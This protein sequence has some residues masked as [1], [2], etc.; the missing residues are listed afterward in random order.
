MKKLI[1]IIS[2]SLLLITSTAFGF[3]WL[4]PDWRGEANTVFA[5]WDNWNADGTAD[6][7]SSTIEGARDPMWINVD[8]TYSDEW[9]GESG[10][11]QQHSNDG[12]MFWLDNANNDNPLKKIRIQVHYFGPD[13]YA[14]VDSF[15]V[16]PDDE[17][18]PEF[19]E[20]FLVDRLI[21]ENQYGA[22]G[23]VVDVYDIEIRP[24]PGE[25]YIAINFG[26]YGGVDAA[27]S[28]V[29]IDTRCVPIPGAV[30]LIASAFMA[31]VGIK[32]KVG[33]F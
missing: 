33:Q 2:L 20:A 12:V 4:P 16:W 32:K 28:Q 18:D 24:N 26:S 3:D 6:S 17:I 15:N 30:W 23:W 7:W 9:Y 10:V 5:E 31:L 14:S 1:A 8:S 19:H 21:L 11:V 25:E 13:G 22:T 29:V 27:I